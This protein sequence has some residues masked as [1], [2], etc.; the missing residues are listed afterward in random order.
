RPNGSR[1]PDAARAGPHRPP[2]CRRRSRRAASCEPSAH[3]IRV[4]GGAAGTAADPP[5]A[6]PPC[7]PSGRKTDGVFGERRCSV[8]GTRSATPDEG[9]PVTEKRDAAAATLLEGS[10]LS[11]WGRAD[12]L[13]Q[14]ERTKRR[15]II[16]AIVVLG[17][18]DAYLL[19][20]LAT[21]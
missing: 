12:V 9:T 4:D 5:A 7:P 16:R 17:L 20:R 15:K 14:R 18:L 10:S 2:P 6:P 21:A 19:Y 3:H 11:R 13:K 8:E 1:H